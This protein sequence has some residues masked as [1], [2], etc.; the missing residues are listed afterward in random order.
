MVV[1]IGKQFVNFVQ[2]LTN[3]LTSAKPLSD[4]AETFM[5]TTRFF[6]FFFNLFELGMLFYKVNFDLNWERREPNVGP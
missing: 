4:V 3:C 6:V 5:K 2:K 1:F